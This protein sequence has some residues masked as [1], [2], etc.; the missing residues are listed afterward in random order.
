MIDVHSH[1]VFGVDDGAKTIDQSIQIIKE[2]EK[3][4]FTKIIATPHYMDHYYECDK[5][6]IAER[7]STIKEKLAESRCGVEIIQGN[8]IYFTRHIN[9]F[10]EDIGE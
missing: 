8:E 7:I 1:I 4:G 2:A 3:A 5:N 6:E 9:E 10:L